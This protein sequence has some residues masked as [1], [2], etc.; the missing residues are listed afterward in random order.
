[1]D[2]SK[3]QEGVFDPDYDTMD[4]E[5]LIRIAEEFRQ[6]WFICLAVLLMRS[7]LRVELS[8][9]EME[10]ARKLVISKE[11]SP[12]GEFIVFTAKTREDENAGS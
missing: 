1:M 12:D 4:K 5:Q 2:E 8:F 7:D 9:E 11:E 6:A 10:S 3:Q